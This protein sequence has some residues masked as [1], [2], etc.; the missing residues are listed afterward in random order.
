L[1]RFQGAAWVLTLGFASSAFAAI[2]FTPGHFYGTHYASN[3]ITEFDSAGA[4]VGSISI[5]TTIVNGLRGTAFGPDGLLYTIGVRSTGFKVLA[6]D[7]SGT[8]HQTY[9]Y[10][11]SYFAGGSYYGKIV[12]DSSGNFRVGGFHELM[13]FTRGQPDSGTLLRNFSIAVSDVVG[14]PSGNLLLTTDYEVYELTPQGATVRMVDP[15]PFDIRGVEYYAPADELFVAQGGR[16]TKMNGSTFGT[17]SYSSFNGA[18]DMLFASDGRLIVGN[19][20]NRTGFYS[21]DF[22]NLGLFG[23]G[24]AQ[25]VT[26]LVPEPQGLMLI[27]AFPLLARRRRRTGLPRASPG[28]SGLAAASASIGGSSPARLGSRSSNRSAEDMG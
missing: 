19:T 20:H 13:H 12:F 10:F 22:E 5:P 8:I 24:G 25:F 28:R 17:I 23:S 27:A 7:S 16:V 11:N 14:M 26:Q 6:L 2:Q 18:G 15:D 4:P 21:R 1:N 9:N 3:V